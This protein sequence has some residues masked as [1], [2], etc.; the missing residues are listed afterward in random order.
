MA[1]PAAISESEE[2]ATNL[3]PDSQVFLHLHLAV[4]NHATMG[5]MT[6]LGFGPVPS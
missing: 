2:L 5:A 6:H 1:G 3:K 4:L